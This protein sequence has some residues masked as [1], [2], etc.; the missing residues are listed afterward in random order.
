MISDTKNQAD[1][2]MRKSIAS[3]KEELTKIRTGRAHTNLLDHVTV[4]YYG[5][6]V[7]L[8]QAASVT[9]ADARSLTITPWEKNMVPVIEK[10]IMTSDLGLTPVTVGTVIRINLPPLTEERRR[11]LIKVVRNEAEGARVAIRNIRRD[12]NNEL[13]KLLKDKTISEDDDR[14]AQD[15]IQKLTDK[16]IAEVDKALAA[17]EAELMEI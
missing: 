7:P 10:A 12:A 8:T 4:D 15:D 17:K 16:Y 5:S 3:L 2:R 13:K 14:R 1:A 11:D 6:Q 9:V